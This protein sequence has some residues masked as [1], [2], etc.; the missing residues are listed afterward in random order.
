MWSIGDAPAQQVAT[1]FYEYLFSHRGETS[2]SF[3]NGSLSAVALHYTAQQLRLSLDESEYALLT[4][5]PFVH[6]G[7]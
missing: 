4:W 5:I 6:F 1:T 7:L 2:G 3:F